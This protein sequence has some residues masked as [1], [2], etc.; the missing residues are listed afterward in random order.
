MGIDTVSCRDIRMTL[1]YT[2]C[3]HFLLF[4][5]FY[6]S[7]CFI[8]TKDVYGWN[9]GACD[10][11]PWEKWANCD[12]WV[13][14]LIFF[15]KKRRRRR[16]RRKNEDDFEFGVSQLTSTLEVQI[17]HDN[18]GPSRDKPY[19]NLPSIRILGRLQFASK[20]ASRT[21]AVE[22]SWLSATAAWMNSKALTSFLGGAHPWALIHQLAVRLRERMSVNIISIGKWYDQSTLTCIVYSGN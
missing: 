2:N 6:S 22:E 20:G 5:F 13:Q 1:V 16:R 14:L 7:T 21:L 11:W 12:F 18:L 17:P 15:F 10:R 19:A 4:H 9:H 3:Y 8:L